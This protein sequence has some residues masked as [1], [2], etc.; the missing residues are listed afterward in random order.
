MGLRPSSHMPRPTLG[1]IRSAWQ[2]PVPRDRVSAAD[3]P[4][5]SHLARSS[6]S[7]PVS[8]NQALEHSYFPVTPGSLLGRARSARV[9]PFLEDLDEAFVAQRG[10]QSVL[11]VGAD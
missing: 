6:L 7:S 9:Y 11:A 10:R 2:A 1:P 8:K 4:L 3:R 5:L